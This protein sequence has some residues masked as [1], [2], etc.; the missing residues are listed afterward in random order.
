QGGR[1][2]RTH[3]APRGRTHP[4]RARPRNPGRERGDRRDRRTHP[5][6]APPGTT[7]RRRGVGPGHGRTHQRGPGR[8]VRRRHGAPAHDQ[9]LSQRGRGRR[10]HLSTPEPCRST[11]VARAHYE[12]FS[13]EGAVA[14]FPVSLASLDASVDPTTLKGKDVVYRSSAKAPSGTAG[15]RG[16]TGSTRR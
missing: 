3:G 14:A 4:G 9:R 6:G 1:C 7:G 11:P 5:P 13:W 16:K 2:R 12:L 15:D 8:A 10:R